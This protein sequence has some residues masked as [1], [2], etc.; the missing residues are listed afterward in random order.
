MR[1]VIAVILCIWGATPL[2]AQNLPFPADK[3]NWLQNSYSTNLENHKSNFQ[4][5]DHFSAEAIRGLNFASFEL[6]VRTDSPGDSLPVRFAIATFDTLLRGDALFG[7]PGRQ[8][9]GY[10][11]DSLF[12][13]LRHAK[14]SSVQDTIEVNIVEL[15]NTGFPILTSNLFSE[16]Y[17]QTTALEG[18][19]FFSLKCY[20]Q[21]QVPS[22]TA[23]GVM[24]I[25]KGG[26]NQDSLFWRTGTSTDGN[27]LS[28]QPRP[29][30]HRCYPTSFTYFERYARILPTEAGG[31]VFTD[32]NGTGLF[33]PDEDGAS[34]IQAFDVKLFIQGE[35]LITT[36]LA[37]DKS[38]FLYPNPSQGLLFLK[39]NG[40]VNSFKNVQIR[41]IVGQVMVEWTERTCGMVGEAVELPSGIYIVS[42]DGGFQ[43]WIKQ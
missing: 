37:S 33:D 5:I 10:V 2:Q 21:I 31:D 38:D 40:G 1:S 18:G 26:T 8:P 43:K 19:Q 25:Y 14:T 11:L 34:P 28:G 23:I 17:T 20:P 3:L 12:L 41:N 7:F 6:P 32:C 39:C 15:G 16:L 36:A 27:C 9:N 22:E 42:W 35:S 4:I 13:R 24:L 29:V 30:E